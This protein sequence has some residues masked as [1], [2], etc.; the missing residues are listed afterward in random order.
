MRLHV[1]ELIQG[2]GLFLYMHVL[3]SHHYL[4]RW[5]LFKPLAKPHI[6]QSLPIPRER[7]SLQSINITWNP[8]H[9]HPHQ[10]IGLRKQTVAVAGFESQASDN[11]PNDKCIKWNNRDVALDINASPSL[12]VTWYC[13]K[14]S[15]S[16]YL[17]TSNLILIA[18]GISRETILRHHPIFQTVL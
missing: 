12:A 15:S 18:D 11:M 5:L 14:R 13:R 2:L 8:I 17:P 16:R 4:I 3:Q 10:D 7:R 1:H 9:H 6:E